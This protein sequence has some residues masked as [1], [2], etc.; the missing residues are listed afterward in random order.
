MNILYSMGEKGNELYCRLKAFQEEI[1]KRTVKCRQRQSGILYCECGYKSGTVMPD[2][3]EMQPFESWQ[4]WGGRRDSHCWF[5]K[6]I[7]F[8]VSDKRV[9]LRVDTQKDGWDASNPQ[10]MLYVDGKIKQGMDVNHRTAVIS[11]RGEHDVF[12]YAY[13]GTDVD[14]LLDLNLSVETVDEDVERLYYNLFIPYEILSN[15][16]LDSTEFNEII[17]PVNEALNLIDLRGSE[18]DFLSSVKN[19]NEYLERELYGKCGDSDRKVACIGHTHIDVAWKWSVRQTVEKA[20]RSF[21]TVDALMER[22]PRYRFMSSQVP[23]YKAIKEECPE[24]YERI[25]KRVKEGRWEPEGGMYVEPDCNLSSGES[26]IRQFVYGKKFFKDEFGVDSKVM[27]LPDVFGYS[28]AMPQIMKKCGINDFV[29][30]K[31]SWNETNKMPYDT[32][33]WRGI[34]GTE[35][36]THFMTSY[37]YQPDAYEKVRCATYIGTGNPSM[38]RGTYERYQQKMLNKTVFCSVGK[39]DGGGGTTQFD[40]EAIARQERAL[41]GQPVAAWTSVKDFLAEIDGRVEG[42]KRTPVWQGELYLEFHRGTYTSQAKMKKGNRKCEFMLQAAEAIS[43]IAKSFGIDLFDKAEHDKAWETVLLNQFHDILPG[44]SVG[45]V[46]EVAEREHAEVQTYCR[47]LIQKTLDAIAA[48]TGGK[49]LLV[50]NPNSFEYSGAVEV[51]GKRCEVEGIPAK[52]FALVTPKK[53]K[54]KGTYN[55]K[56]LENEFFRLTFDSKMN[57]TSL[58]DKTAGGR[59]LLKKG[60]AIRYAAYQDLPEIYDAW[61]LK[62][63]YKEKAYDVDEVVSVRGI[64][65]GSRVGVEVVRRF[66]ESTVTDRIYLYDGERRIEFD[67]TV[68][69]HTKHTL[70]KREFPIDI[71]TDKASCEIQFGYADRPT[72]SNTSWDWAKYEVCAQKYVDLSESDYGVALINDCKYGHGVNGGTLSLSLLRGPVDPDP[73]CDMGEHTFRYALCP[74]GGTLSQ[75][76]VIR[77]A[78]ELNSPCYAVEATGGTGEIADDFSAVTSAEGRLVIDTLKPAED[79]NGTVVRMYDAYRTRGTET[80]FVG[81]KAKKAYLCDMLENELEEIEITDGKIE[82][83]FKPF[84]I[85][86]L[87]LK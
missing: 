20:Q 57:I 8:P 71:V 37:W 17:L 76:D 74:H 59:E 24:L 15:T 41:P 3:S 26:L 48:K 11:E 62:S 78:Y 35:V 65:D 32:F 4:R 42:D 79:G 83:P 39:G 5:Y 80:L 28:A 10:F 29:T 45:E 14:D 16:P 30:S 75:S 12:L 51:N 34:D 53:V 69:W 55:D 9:E 46:Y 36:M 58:V 67:D 68:D 49:G 60:E 81:V 23:L 2:P 73:D 82:V 64:G 52:G 44:S 63:Y 18:Q 87:K 50:F 33:R 40:C 70:L 56:A 21:A 7:D 54:C 66:G 86:T 77:L 43:V 13:T 47:N 22:Y 1:R 84:E 31:I 72:H 85:I 27:W 19:A 6:K 25:K 38:L 61:E